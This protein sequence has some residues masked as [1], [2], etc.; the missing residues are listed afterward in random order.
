MSQSTEG[1]RVLRMTYAITS[2][3][4]VLLQ[5]DNSITFVGR[6]VCLFVCIFLLLPF[7][8]TPDVVPSILLLLLKSLRPPGYDGG[9]PNENTFGVHGYDVITDPFLVAQASP[10]LCLIALLPETR[11][12]PNQQ[13]I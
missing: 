1:R 11:S 10:R 5:R 2:R 4:L 9:R 6:C 3:L 8:P 13:Y 12:R 7:R